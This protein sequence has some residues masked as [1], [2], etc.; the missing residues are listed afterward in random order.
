MAT[1]ATRQPARIIPTSGIKGERERESRATSALLSVL[2]AVDEFGRA[3]L[4]ERFGAPAGAARAYVEVTLKMPGGPDVRPDGLVEIKRGKKTWVALFE[5]K[6]RASVLRREQVESYVDAA[7]HHGY[8]AVVTISNQ[9]VP[10]TGDHPSG[11]RL[12]KLSKV[13]LHHISWVALL[14]EAVMQKEHRGVADTDQDW[15]L[16]ELIAYLQHENAGTMRS[17][18]IGPH[19]TRVLDDVKRRVLGRNDE[20]TRDVIGRWEEISRYLCLELGRELGR[21]VRQIIPR[22]DLKD[23][24]RRRA[25]AA[26]MLA[27]DGVLECVLRVP[28]T[29]SDITLRADL[30]S[31]RLSASLQVDAPGEG[32]PRT[33]VNWLVRQLRQN[34]P[35]DLH[36]HTAFESRRGAV[37]HPLAAL[38]EQPA[39]TLLADRSINPQYF[40]LVLTRDM[41][42][43]R[44]GGKRP[45]VRSVRALLDEFYRA[46][47]HD[48]YAWKPR[49]PRPPER[50]EKAGTVAGEGQDAA[51][52]ASE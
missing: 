4:R 40:R 46:V 12:H 8:D 33:R 39:A 43:S 36:V 5:V 42:V 16:G 25:R 9:I 3:I 18:D 38:I 20:G 45:F 1:T 37:P 41:G 35:S 44:G 17:E 52:R 14:T 24:A 11:V 2:T 32:M 23:P 21:D 7:R 6:T 48:L 30:R 51:P 47:V 10:A 13:K 28:D 22:R 15:I 34:A 19:W 49:T 31:Q 29:V 50:V 27:E 26:R